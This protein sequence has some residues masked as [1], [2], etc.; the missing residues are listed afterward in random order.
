[1]KFLKY[2]FIVFT[3]SFFLSLKAWS[4]NTP[5][6]TYSKISL[7]GVWDYNSLNEN[8]DNKG[9]IA[10]ISGAVEKRQKKNFS[11]WSIAAV[12]VLLYLYR[13]FCSC[14]FL[15]IVTANDYLFDINNKEESKNWLKNSI[16][17]IWRLNI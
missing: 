8:T 3:F 13:D 11:D 12:W 17:L 1:M 6:F 16:F 7:G 14:F 5:T 4:I 10:L 2:N 9:V 15:E